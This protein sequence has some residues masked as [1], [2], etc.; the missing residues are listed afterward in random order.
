LE[1]ERKMATMK[2]VFIIAFLFLIP[3]LAKADSV[4]TFDGELTDPG[5]WHA[6]FPQYNTHCN[7]DLDGVMVFDNNY[8]VLA[9][10]WTDGTHTLNQ[11]NSNM[12]FL[13]NQNTQMAL[14]GK[15]GPYPPLITWSVS[16]NAGDVLLHTNFDGPGQGATS[17]NFSFANGQLIG[18]GQPNL[19][20]T[21]TWTEVIST[22]EPGSALLLG[23]GITALALI[24]PLR[25]R[26]A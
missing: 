7:C 26:A 24:I 21:G 11:N 13:N 19:G 9:Y 15:P 14:G 8:N 16:I 22:P 25:M 5:S 12:V 20:P 17:V 10:S 1:E 6:G 4:W 2:R 18:W 3:A 23:I